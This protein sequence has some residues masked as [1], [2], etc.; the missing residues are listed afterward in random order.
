[1]RD[2]TLQATALRYAAGDLP[3]SESEAFELL[4]ATDEAAQDALAEAVRLSAAAIG[5]A[6]PAPTPSFR[7][8]VRARVRASRGSPLAWA[9]CGATAV[10]VA[11]IVGLQLSHT[12]PGKSPE[13]Q[14]TPV[15]AP[16]PPPIAVAPEPRPVLLTIAPEMVP[17]TTAEI[18]AEF[19]T[20]ER[21]QKAHDD[22]LRRRQ[23]MRDIRPP[24]GVGIG[25]I[26]S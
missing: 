11:T 8:R 9:A 1:M 24:S 6:A 26:D 22:E 17:A 18:W 15:A 19:S 20:S 23:R 16:S 21:I 2:P 25:M 5:Q 13:L 12:E 3:P 4:L 14:A 10:A 7:D